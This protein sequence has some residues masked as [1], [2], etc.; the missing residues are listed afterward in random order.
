MNAEDRAQEDLELERLA[1]R[2]VTSKV[3]IL[4]AKEDHRQMSSDLDRKLPPCWP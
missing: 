4:V 2:D 3:F 1:I